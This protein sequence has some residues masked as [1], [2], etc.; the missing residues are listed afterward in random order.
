MLLEPLT[1]G[2][3]AELI[4]NLRGTS[5]LPA[6]SEARI[7]EAAEGNPLFAEELLAMVID[8]TQA[9]RRGEERPSGDA[10]RLSLPP[11]IQA[12]LS[13][14]LEL[15]SDDERA[16]VELASVEGTQFHRG[17]LDDLWLPDR[18]D[19]S[20]DRSLSALVRR[21]LIRPDRPT[22]S[23]TGRLD[24]R[25][26]LIRD[27]AYESLQKDARAELHER[28]AAWL[29]STQRVPGYLSSRRS[30]ATTLSAPIGT[31]SCSQAPKQ[32]QVP[33][34]PCIPAAGIR[35]AERAEPKRSPRGD[36]PARAG[37]RATRGW[38]SVTSD[39]PR[40]SRG[41]ADRGGQAREGE[42]GARLGRRIGDRA[43]RRTRVR[44]CRRAAFQFLPTRG[45]HRARYK[46]SRGSRRARASRL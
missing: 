4:A 16:L 40:R 33:R 31:C 39:P 35:G 24:S 18:P 43:A 22:S 8:D 34:S 14:R 25:H 42:I 28:F 29:K 2:D 1:F 19:V 45:G 9:G 46:R 5:P 20:L 13:A 17:A 6:K 21:D 41:D 11:T 38:R 32:P 44:A 10:S 7:A 36:R 3:C 37:G 27:A 23:G 26:V 12:L 15:L 30:S